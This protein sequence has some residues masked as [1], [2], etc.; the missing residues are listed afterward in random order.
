MT[1]RNSRVLGRP[2]AGE[3]LSRA[4]IV[5]LEKAPVQ[6]KPLRPPVNRENVK[7]KA[8]AITWRWIVACPKCGFKV[9]GQGTPKPGDRMSRCGGCQRTLYLA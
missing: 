1:N 7:V 2:K 3:R 6:P 8:S 4:E 5:S 9:A